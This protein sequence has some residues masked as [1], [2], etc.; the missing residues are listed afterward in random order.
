MS[1]E[2]PKSNIKDIFSCSLYTETF[3]EGKLLLVV[4]TKEGN[5]GLFGDSRVLYLNTNSKVIGYSEWCPAKIPLR[6]IDDVK[7]VKK[8]APV[9]K[10]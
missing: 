4:G 6:T 5:S 9:D 3:P 8:M 7:F 1:K 10:V 2:K